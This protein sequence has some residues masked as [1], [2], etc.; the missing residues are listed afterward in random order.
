M[1]QNLA[2]LLLSDQVMS[3]PWERYFKPDIRI[4]VDVQEFSGQ[5]V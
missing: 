4:T 3:R 5:L 2:L 1:T